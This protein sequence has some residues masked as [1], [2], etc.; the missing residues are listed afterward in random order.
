MPTPQISAIICTHNRDQ[1]LGAAIDSLLS[2]QTDKAFEIIVV[3][4][5][6]TDHTRTVI[7]SRLPHPALHSVYEPR[8]GLSIARNTGAAHAQGEVLAYL[9][10]DAIASPQWLHVLSAAFQ[11]DEHLA[12]AGGRIALIWPPSLSRPAWLSDNLTGCLGA[13][14]LGDTPRPIHHAGLT[15]R[16]LNYAI[17]R[18]FFDQVGGFNRHLG[19]RGNRLLSN[20]EL[21]MTEQALQQGWRV[22]YLPEAEVSHQVAPERVRPVWFLRRSWWQG[23]SECYR[24]QLLN[25]SGGEQI[26]RGVERCCRGL[27]Q[28]FKATG[29]PAQGF[30]HAVYAYGQ[31]GYLTVAIRGMVWPSS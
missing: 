17:R 22:L 2:Q 14:D 10:D 5:A 12:I 4:N 7:Q 20:E 23:I 1:Y 19:R 29:N 30:D 6:S 11:Q 9:D 31:L 26:W 27:Y 8:L 3:D 28:A 21:Y 25:R 16:G 15:P 13:Y 18:T 24:E